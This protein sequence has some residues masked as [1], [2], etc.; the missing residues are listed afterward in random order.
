[1]KR[2]IMC[3]SI[4]ALSISGVYAQDADIRAYKQ[5][6]QQELQQIIRV[7]KQQYVQEAEKRMQARKRDVQTE[8]E[9]RRSQLMHRPDGMSAYKGK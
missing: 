8:L 6:Q 5:Q 1:M 2:F 7:Q 4:A 3:L 9:A